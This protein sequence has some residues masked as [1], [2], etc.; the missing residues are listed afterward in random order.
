MQQPYK[1][2]SYAA[3]VQAAQ[4]CSSRTSRP[5]M[6]Q[7]YKPPSYPNDFTAKVVVHAF[8][9]LT[10][11]PRFIGRMLTSLKASAVNLHALQFRLPI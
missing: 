8:I 6:Q 5:A 3:A 2:P 7:P 4:L 1:P 11:T 10:T 9:F